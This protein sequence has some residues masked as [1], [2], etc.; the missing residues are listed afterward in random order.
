MSGDDL[1][2]VAALAAVTFVLGLLLGFVDVF[3]RE[4]RPHDRLLMRR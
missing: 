3:D 2:I 4:V 1:G